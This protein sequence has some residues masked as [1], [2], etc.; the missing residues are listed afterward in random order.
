MFTPLRFQA[1]LAAGGLALMPFV[2]MQLTFPHAGKMMSA[3]DLG[4]GGQGGGLFLVGVMVL[5]TAFHFALTVG[6]GRQLLAW[7][8][9]RRLA[10]E[11][12]ADPRRNSGIFSPAISLGMTVNVLLGPVAFFLPSASTGVARLATYAILIYLPLW[13]ALAGLSVVTLRISMARPLTPADLNFVW[14]LDVFAWAM[15]ALAGSSIAATTDSAAVSALA[16]A[17]AVASFG[18]GLSIYGVKG[19]VLLRHLARARALPVDPMKPA[20]FVT[21]PI[22]CLFGVAAFKV[23][24]PLDHLLGTQTSGAAL[25]AVLTFF[26]VAALWT[27]ACAVALRAWFVRAFPRPEFYATQWGLVCVMVGLE[28]LA[29]YTHAN[30]LAHPLLIAFAYG[31]TAVATAVFAV[32]YAKFSGMYSSSPASASPRPST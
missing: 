12:I 18:V 17:L 15:A 24:R 30:Y 3:Q 21:V 25:A 14:L 27:F 9:D 2:L 26:A 4:S 7:L 22:N 1:S 11:L 32:V 8:A 28:V 20:L 19:A 29:V 6:S 10:R 13:V 16:T 5:A 31:S 23:S